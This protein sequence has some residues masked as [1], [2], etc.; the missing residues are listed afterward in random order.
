MRLK[1]RSRPPKSQKEANMG[2]SQS[3]DIMEKSSDILEATA[4]V[5][6]LK[7]ASMDH[8]YTI[9]KEAF[10]SIALSK[11]R[12]QSSNHNSHSPLRTNL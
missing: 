11:F 2:E 1:V 5:S 12:P 6:A 9:M 3:I 10:S 4:S 7:V 8:L